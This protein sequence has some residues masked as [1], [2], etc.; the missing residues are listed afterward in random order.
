MI[1]PK[2]KDVPPKRTFLIV[3]SLFAV[4]ALAFSAHTLIAAPKNPSLV[5]DDSVVVTDVVEEEGL[6]TVAPLTAQDDKPIITTY[7][8][9][10]GDTL[11]SIASQF[12]ISTN[13]LLWAND[14][15]KK[16]VIKE[17]QKLTILPVSG[18]RYTV[19][20]GDTLSGI[21]QKFDA[22]IE[23][24][25]SFNDLEDTK[26]I[27]AGMAL[28]IPNGE[29]P[30]AKEPVASPTKK[31]ATSTTA[32]KA[33]VKKLQVKE[34]VPAPTANV[35]SATDVDT[36]VKTV[37]ET[38]ST[39]KGYFTM[40]IPSGILT[41]GLHGYNSVDFGAPVGTPVVAAASGT[42]LVSKPTGHNGG[43]GHYIV[44]E[45]DNGTQTL[46]AHLSSVSVGLG[47][48]VQK[49]QKIA[50]SGNTGRSTGPHLHFE[51]RGGVN[52]WVGVKKMT[53]F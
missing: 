8:V 44:I 46:Y 49:G 10:S 52:P 48:T 47:D 3:L 42:V 24:I 39:E 16:S 19:I 32:P 1:S 36:A 35:A 43:Y 30:L 27:K 25:I 51:V 15:T 5:K 31:A 7:T 11:S 14:L 23:E 18:V 22:H 4:S 40:P 12:S 9:K 45:H 2:I 17:G 53:Q 38:E 13:T 29:L 34:E 41:Q 28:V 21:A 20:K 37:V 50:L 26:T 6:G 33:E